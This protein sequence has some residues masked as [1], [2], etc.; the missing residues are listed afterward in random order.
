MTR[1]CEAIH[2]QLFTQNRR[3]ICGAQAYV[4]DAGHRVSEDPPLLPRPDDARIFIAYSWS[5]DGKWIAGNALRSAEFGGSGGSGTIAAYSIEQQ[6]YDL[7]AA[8]GTPS[9]WLS[10]NRTVIYSGAG[11]IR[12]ID[13]IAKQSRTIAVPGRFETLAGPAISPDGRT[14]YYV[15]TQVQA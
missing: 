12:A 11:T 13:R 2:T 3:I 15:V 4:I 7:L 9:A 14:L 5:P 8:G 6:R 10:D 1:F